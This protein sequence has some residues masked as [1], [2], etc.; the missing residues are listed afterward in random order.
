[1]HLSPSPA[2]GITAV[3]EVPAVV[4]SGQNEADALNAS[5]GN[6][7]AGPAPERAED[8]VTGGPTSLS[9]ALP[10]GEEFERGLASLIGADAGGPSDALDD[11]ELNRSF[12]GE[13]ADAPS[14]DTFA[15]LA[16]APSDDPLAAPPPPPP[17]DTSRGAAASP[18]DWEPA[19]DWLDGELA[20]VE[21]TPVAA[22]A[23]SAAAPEPPAPAAAAPLTRRQ[24]R[25]TLTDDVGPAAAPRASG[26]RT[27]S[28]RRS[29][30]EVRAML[31]RYRR[32]IEDG[33]QAPGSED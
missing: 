11:D 21:P 7:A 28:T 18:P 26:P 1:V 12:W 10:D 25:A 6:G 15:D 5:S 23:A 32:G 33:R 29:P 17:A 4:L 16:D 19:P 2:G 3:V 9:D 13:L 22:A 20:S 14:D 31:Y 8:P 30:E 27:A 24:P